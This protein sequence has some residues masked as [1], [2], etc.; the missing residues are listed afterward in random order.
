MD[1]PE[2]EILVPIGVA[3]V[4]REGA[5][6]TVVSFSRMVTFVQAVADEVAKEGI[7]LEVIDLR[8][9]KPLDL[10]TIYASIRKTHRLLIVEEGHAFGSIASEIAFRVQSELFDELDG[11]IGRVCQRE[12]PMPYPKV[13]EAETLPN[14]RR[15]KEAVMEAVRVYE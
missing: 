1:I 13:L 2:G 14:R 10:E 11:S 12:T 8:T 3:K 15:I 4:V 9:I 7:S 5:D 6:L